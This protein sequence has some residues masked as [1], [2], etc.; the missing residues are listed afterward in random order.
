MKNIYL[1]QEIF[2]GKEFVLPPL[3]YAYDALEP[4]VDEATVRLHHDKHHAAYVAGANAALAKLKEIAEG[5]GDASLT[6]HWVR[7][8]SF[9]KSGH[10]LHSILW[11]N[12][13]PAPQGAPSGKLAEKLTASFGGVDNFIRLFK[14]ASTG[15]EGSGW[16]ILGYD[17]ASGA[18]SVLGVEKHQN[19]TTPGLI[20]LLVLDVW[21]HAY[22]L[23]HQNNRAGHV[24]DFM[25]IV[26]WDDVAKRLETACG[27]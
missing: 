16:G 27:C 2:N 18:L 20:P 9:H 25:K 26:N 3:P 13:T 4:Y 19:L 8:L 15:V 22:Y 14:A 12:M 7:Q 17:P 5:T 10:V 24:E 1:P 21:E 11:N 6:T 23:K